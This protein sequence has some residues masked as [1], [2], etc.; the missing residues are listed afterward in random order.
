M[1]LEKI[2]IVYFSGTH[3]T[4]AY[5]RVI[6]DALVDLN[7]AVQLFDVTP[8]ASRQ[9]PFPVGDYD[10]FVFGFPVYGDFAP[11]VIN[12]WLPTLGGQ[13]EPCVQFFTY[14][15]RTSG[16]AHFHT[17]ELLEQGPNE[18][19]VNALINNLKFRL[20]L[21]YQL[22]EKLNELNAS[23]NTYQEQQT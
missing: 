2:A 22:K 7:C 11:R 19:T 20:N 9:N 23:E 4:K 3:V 15:A 10:A 1:T 8:Y 12:E 14:G 16:Y 18:A 21:L 17:K 6:R 13:G 5:A